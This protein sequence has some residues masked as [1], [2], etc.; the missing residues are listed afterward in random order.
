MPE[1]LAGPQSEVQ[2]VC[3]AAERASGWPA[4]IVEKDLWVTWALGIL[5][6]SKQPFYS[7]DGTPI[8]LAFKGGTSL[9]MAYHVITR[10]SEDVDSH[11]GNR[12]GD[13]PAG[14]TRDLTGSM[15]MPWL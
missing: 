13:R 8:R 2:D 4:A 12:V 11:D 7:G 15:S 3:R 6:E 10:F 9:S 1:L 5:F 14:L